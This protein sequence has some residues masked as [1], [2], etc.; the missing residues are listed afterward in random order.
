M[1]TLSYHVSYN[2]IDLFSEGLGVITIGIVGKN[3][4][5]FSLVR[6][7]SYVLSCLPDVHMLFSARNK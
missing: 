3:R 4:I 5:C 1:G 7:Q 2:N 6:D